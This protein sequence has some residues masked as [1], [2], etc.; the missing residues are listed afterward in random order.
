VEHE[1]LVQP[2][3]DVDQRQRRVQAVRKRAPANCVEI[4]VS[5]VGQAL[6]PGGEPIEHE[7]NAFGRGHRPDQIAGLERVGSDEIV[8]PLEPAGTQVTD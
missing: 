2:P 3:H 8:R 6:A 1:L 4:L 7:S 5:H